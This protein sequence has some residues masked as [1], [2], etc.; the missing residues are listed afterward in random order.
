[1]KDRVLKRTFLIKEE[2]TS[3]T[4]ESMGYAGSLY[5]NFALTC[6]ADFPS[7]PAAILLTKIIGRRIPNLAGLFIA[8]LLFGCVALVK[9]LKYLTPFNFRPL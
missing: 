7:I 2:C 3:P 8:S 4:Q 1:M 5:V 6:V 9:Y